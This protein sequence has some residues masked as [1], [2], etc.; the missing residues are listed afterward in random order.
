MNLSGEV[1]ASQSFDDVELG[2]VSHIGLPLNE[3]IVSYGDAGNELVVATPSDNAFARVV[4]NPAEII[5][6]KLAAPADAFETS[7]KAVEGGVE[8]TVTARSYVRDLFCMVDKVDAKR[9]S[10][11]A[12]SPCW[13]ARASRCT[14]PPTRS[15]I[16]PR[17]QRP[18][19]CAVPTISNASGDVLAA[20]R[21]MPSGTMDEEGIPLNISA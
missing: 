8:L 1:L 7:A 18:T 20:V 14:S 10:P 6:Q 11:K 12:W 16:R 5:D 4:F 19:C 9:P 13:P 3:D 2:A 21:G 15:P 17:S